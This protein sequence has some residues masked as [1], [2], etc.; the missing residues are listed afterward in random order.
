[1]SCWD[2]EIG[3]PSSPW[4]MVVQRANDG[5]PASAKSSGHFCGSMPAWVLERIAVSQRDSNNK[6]KSHSAFHPTILAKHWYLSKCWCQQQSQVV[7]V[8][9]NSL[10]ESL[11][12]VTDRYGQISEYI[13]E[14]LLRTLRGIDSGL[15]TSIQRTSKKVKISFCI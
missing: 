9:A 1:M 14:P 11:S 10:Y 4:M 3:P 6:K 5:E 15:I 2:A 7:K 12:K 13:A 8:C